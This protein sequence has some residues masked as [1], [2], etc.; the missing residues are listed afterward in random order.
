M[1]KIPY[2][3]ASS[4]RFQRKLQFAAINNDALYK[5]REKSLQFYFYRRAA[6][7]ME[8]NTSVFDHDLDTGQPDIPRDGRATPGDRGVTESNRE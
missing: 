4:A 8:A 7:R 1:K 3:S 6:A 2:H 5:L